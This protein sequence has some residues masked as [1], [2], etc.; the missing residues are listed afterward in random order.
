MNALS[1]S[2]GYLEVMKQ[3]LREYLPM[4]EESF[5][6]NGGKILNDEKKYIFSPHG[7]GQC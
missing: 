6:H 4:W 1:P 7:H 5:V 3:L 2:H